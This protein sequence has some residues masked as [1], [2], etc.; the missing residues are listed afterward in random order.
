MVDSFKEEVIEKLGY[1]VYRLVDPRNGKTFYVG[2]GQGNRVFDHAR[3]APKI[4][5]DEK[6][7]DLKLEKIG[8]ITDASC[9]V[10]TVVH[11]HGLS[12]ES[13]LLVE[14]ALIDAYPALTNRVAGHGS[15]EYG[16]RT[17][18]DIVAFY[19]AEPFKADRDLILVSIGRSFESAVATDRNDGKRVDRIYD[20]ARLA[21]K[22][23]LRRA[24]RYG[25][26]LAHVG[27]FVVGA[28]VPTEWKPVTF[29]NFPGVSSE[30]AKR[31]GFFGEPAPQDVWDRYVGRRVPLPTKRGA[32]NPIRY[33]NMSAEKGV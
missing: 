19:G 32:A 28:F 26:V 3:G 25:L 31:L 16:C 12:E 10:S 30:D 5:A 22:I 21:W 33:L 11:R 8:E 15:P 14:A 4:A 9:T 23:N 1:Y 29:E 27:G 2:K 13:A 17:T 18:D 24:K 7:D 20:A 6:L